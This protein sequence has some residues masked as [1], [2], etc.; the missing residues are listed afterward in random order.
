MDKNMK[1]ARFELRMHGDL[2]HK[3]MKR[4]K[5]MGCSLAEYINRLLTT[6]LKKRRVEA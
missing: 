1:D 4:A 5:K 6:D 3:A 2:K